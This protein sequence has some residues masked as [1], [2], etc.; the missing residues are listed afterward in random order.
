[1]AVDRAPLVG[2]VA[3]PSQPGAL[4]LTL[5]VIDW[6]EKRGIPFRV[7]SDSAPLLSRKIPDD[8]ILARDDIPT[9]CNPLLVLG[10][11]G[12]L[13]SVAHFP[14]TP[15]PTIVGVNM[16]TL[17]FLTETPREELY[18]ALESVLAGTARLSRRSLLHASVHRKGQQPVDCYAVND[19]VLSKEALARIFGVTITIDGDLAANLRGDGV[20]VASPCG[21][22]AYSLAAGGAIVHPEVQAL[23]ITPICPHSLTSR[24]L[25]V[26][27]SSVVELTV[28]PGLS[29]EI[30]SVYLTID[31]QQ[32]MALTNGDC[33]VVQTSEHSID[34]VGLPGRSYYQL[35]RAKLM[36]ANQ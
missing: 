36:W 13:I 10:G 19:I 29:R 20:I 3:K 11:D 22:T 15:P 28:G 24:P 17:G 2:I 21:S 12:T 4:A 33:V 18:T 26:P 35:L 16:G 6:L 25:V 7:D 31:G 30:S 23:L 9:Q 34:F 32:G 14:A 8:L 27:G 5:E 1:M